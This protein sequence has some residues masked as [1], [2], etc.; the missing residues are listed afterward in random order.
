V[1]D[2]LPLDSDLVRRILATGSRLLHYR[3]VGELGRGGMGEVYRAEDEKLGRQVALKVLSPEVV[4]DP[5]RL[6]R[7]QREARAAAALNHPHIVTVHSVDEAEG[8]HF[9]TMELVEGETLGHRIPEGGMPLEELF[10]LAIPMADA[11]AAAHEHGITHRDLKPDNVMIDRKGRVKILD[12]GLAK[13]GAV[14]AAGA[15]DETERGHAPIT[16][17]GL[18]IGTVPYMSPEQLEGRPV[19]ARSDIFS[20]GVILYQMAAG[21]RPFRGD[22]TAALMSAIL[23]DTPE[24]L[25]EVRIDLPRHLGRIIALCL[26]KKPENRYQSALDV[27]NELRRLRQEIESGETPLPGAAAS[28]AVEGGTDG[29]PA[30]ASAPPDP[31]AAGTA[32][33]PAALTGRSRPTLLLIAVFAANWFETW[34]ETVAHQGTPVPRLGYAIARSMHRLEGLLS[35]DGHDLTNPLAVYGFSISYFF[36]L[37]VLAVA[38]AVVLAGRPSPVPYRVFARAVAVTYL[39]S[40]PFFVFFPVPERWAYPDSGAILLSDLWTSRLIEGFR[41]ISGLDNC[42][43]SF[44]ASLTVVVAAVAFVYRLRFRWSVAALGGTVLLATFALGIHWL[45]DVAAGVAAGVLGT[46]LAVR[47]ERAGASGPV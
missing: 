38:T 37:P 12:F 6:A 8:H 43:P 42:F 1:S 14:P 3:I 47:W 28:A 29:G 10:D 18:V 5:D 35:F 40:L 7:F 13:R 21:R 24:P 36:V 27:R 11:V 16:Q 26:E 44:H 30:A 34:L 4:A 41:P 39:V 46:A 17:E 19:D 15:G 33:A 2:T 32:P 45:A 22:N 23:R 9:L 31:A 20:L 25:T